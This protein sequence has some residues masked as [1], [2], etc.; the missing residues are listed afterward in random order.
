MCK[1]G[2]NPI[3][4]VSGLPVNWFTRTV[5]ARNIRAVSRTVWLWGSFPVM[6]IAGSSGFI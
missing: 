6:T 1:A 4:R 3:Y 5:E 2:L